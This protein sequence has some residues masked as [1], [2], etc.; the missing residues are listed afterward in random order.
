MEFGG[1]LKNLIEIRGY[2]YRKLAML[3]D[4]DHTYISKIVNNKMGPPSPEIL[5]RMAKPLGITYE[6]LMKAAGYLGDTPTT[7]TEKIKTAL[8]DD[9]EL[10]AFWDELSR[11]EDLQLM[12]KQVRDLSPQSIKKIVRIIRAIEDEEASED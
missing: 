3:A 10:S 6:E 9:P 5:Q 12:F 4:V 7:P 2:S 1:Y 8:V 11:R